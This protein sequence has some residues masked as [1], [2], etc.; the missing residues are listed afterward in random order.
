[1]TTVFLSHR[2]ADRARCA[3]LAAWLQS[4]GVHVL[5]DMWG[6]RGGDDVVRWMEDALARADVVLFALPREGMGD[7]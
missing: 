2:T 4:N 6:A 3:E 5:F 1:M 7:S